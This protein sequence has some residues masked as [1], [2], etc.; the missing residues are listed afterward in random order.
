MQCTGLVKILLGAF[1]FVMLGGCKTPEP[2]IVTRDNEVVITQV[3]LTLA[4]INRLKDSLKKEPLDILKDCQLYISGHITLERDDLQRRDKMD[5]GKPILT[6]IYT[7]II[8]DINAL[9]PGTASD[10]A[11][12]GIIKVGFEQVEANLLEFKQEGGA[13]GYFFL[14]YTPPAADMPAAGD[15]IGTITY[16][17]EIYKLKYAERPYLLIQIDQKYQ[18]VLNSQKIR[19]RLLESP[20]P[21]RGGA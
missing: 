12:G 21:A 7:R 13:D 18:E 20:P 8:K 17:G 16:G 3:P 1:V 9:T 15:E 14:L 10:I 2:A 19:G 11:P 6:D 4:L 5:K